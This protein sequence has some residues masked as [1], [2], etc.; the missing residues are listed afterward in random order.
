RLCQ[1]VGAP[2]ATTAPTTTTPAPTTAAP[3]GTVPTTIPGVATTQTGPTATPLDPTQ[4]QAAT[5]LITPLGAQHAPAGAKAVGSAIAGNFQQ[6][7][8]LEAQVQ[9]N[10]GKCYTVVGVG[11]P[12]VT[13][14]DI[15]LVPALP[16]PGLPAATM[17]A[18]NTVASTAIVGDKPNCFK[19]AFPM[20]GMM[21][22]VMTVSQG[23]GVAAAQVFEK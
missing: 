19:W 20:S 2:G 15:A 9:M 6:G 11:L 21:K 4:A 1:T 12:P 7:Q 5:Q 16:I 14:L 18:D 3:A 22:V 17:A 23:S 10:P 8:S 13:N